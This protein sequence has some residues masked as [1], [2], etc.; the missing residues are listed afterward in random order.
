MSGAAAALVLPAIER[1]RFDLSGS[2]A[3]GARAAAALIKQ[4]NQVL[5]GSF[6]LPELVQKINRST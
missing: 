6:A 4:S 1:L 2:V 3:G 5:L